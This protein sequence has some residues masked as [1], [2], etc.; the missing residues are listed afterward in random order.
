MAVPKKRTSVSR[1]GKRRAGQHHKL[2]RKHPMTCPNCKAPT[3]PH[4]AC[5]S[6]GTYKGREVFAMKAD[7]S[8]AEQAQA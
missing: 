7:K 6:C 2:Y 1:K 3:M 5:P 8:T 4:Y